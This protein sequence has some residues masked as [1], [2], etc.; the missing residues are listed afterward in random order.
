M[1]LLSFSTQKYQACMVAV[2]IA[3]KCIMRVLQLVNCLPVIQDLTLVNLCCFLFYM[4]HTIVA[5]SFQQN[6]SLQLPCGKV[7]SLSYKYHWVHTH[8]HVHT[9]RYNMISNLVI[10]VYQAGDHKPQGGHKLGALNRYFFS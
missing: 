8:M 4:L 1:F 3:R 7:F 2:I 6:S 5:K 9:H 10:R